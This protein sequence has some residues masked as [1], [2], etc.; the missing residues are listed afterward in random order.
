MR[1]F[2]NIIQEYTTPSKENQISKD[3]FG[4]ET[5]S[6]LKNMDEIVN[7]NI[8][9]PAEEIKGV[10]NILSTYKAVTAESSAPMNKLVKH[11][12]SCAGSR[13]D[14]AA[15]QRK[16]KMARLRAVVRIAEPD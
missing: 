4:S 2:I 10:E 5:L 16:T 1:K 6:T 11:K 13:R 12:F 9:C 3:A 15:I 14:A 8:F 7:F